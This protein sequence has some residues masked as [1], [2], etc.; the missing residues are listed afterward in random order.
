M[1][2]YFIDSYKNYKRR[3]VPT[4]RFVMRFLLSFDD[5]NVVGSVSDTFRAVSGWCGPRI[6]N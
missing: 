5:L 3:R 4:T 6:K 2:V 1:S